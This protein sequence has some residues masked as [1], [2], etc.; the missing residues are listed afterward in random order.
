[1]RSDIE[2]H[3]KICEVCQ[4]YK[5][6]RKNYGLLPPVQH[7]T[8]PWFTVCVDLIGPWTV[9]SPFTLPARSRGPR[10]MSAPN[11]E[12]LQLLALTIIDPATSWLELVALSDKSALT[13][14][15]AFDQHWLSRYPRPLECVHD[16]GS[17]FV[18]YEFQEL[19]QSYGITIKVTTVANPQANSVIERVHQV[20]ATMLRSSRLMTDPI[21]TFQDIQIRLQSIQ[22][23]VNT[24][25]HTTLRS[26]PAQF[27]FGRDMIMPTTY[28]AN[29]AAIQHRKQLQTD[30]AN[31]RENAS[32]IPH[33]F[34]VN[35]KVL[36]RRSLDNLGKLARPTLGPFRIVD[37]DQVPINGTVIIDRGNAFERIN[38]R[39]LVPYFQSN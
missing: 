22:W 4:K 20:L 15:R 31:Q 39:R 9:P 13:V 36:I 7:T 32:R 2:Q 21:K 25:F 11:N 5:R 23:A 24:T 29:W 18:G 34:R 8:H 1:M 37:V 35:D 30:V 19:L 14:A 27:V 6:Q 33:E 26:T 10:L 16:N 38:I 12:P 28:L 17:K 3:V